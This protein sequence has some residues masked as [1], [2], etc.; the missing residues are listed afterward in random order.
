M[1]VENITKKGVDIVINGENHKARFTMAGLAYL[2]EKYGSV[3]KVL[4]VFQEMTS[5]TLSLPEIGAM[6]DLLFA[7]LLH[8]GTGITIDDIM[9]TMDVSEI[10][11]ITPQLIDAF[12][13]SMGIGSTGKNPPKA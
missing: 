11:D 9:E 2:A 4:E 13:M 5:G 12:T 1:G 3:N 8:E 6:A 10:I 7:G